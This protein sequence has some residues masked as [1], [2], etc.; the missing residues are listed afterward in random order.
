MK[1][2]WTKTVKG[3]EGLKKRWSGNMRRISSAHIYLW[4]WLIVMVTATRRD[5][6]Q[7]ASV[8]LCV[9]YP[10]VIGELSSVPGCL[11]H[12]PD[13]KLI[14]CTKTQLQCVLVR[15]QEWINTLDGCS[16]QDRQE[17]PH[18]ASRVSE[19]NPES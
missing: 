2:D 15:K 6:R 18:G 16:W 4:V 12:L 13:G 10:D 14:N 17:S 5:E 9:L 11:L 19:L 8:S 3:K 7:T 1:Q